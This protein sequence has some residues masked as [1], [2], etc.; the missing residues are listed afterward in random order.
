M[1]R[2][3]AESSKRPYML[4]LIWINWMSI[5]M[6]QEVTGRP[7]VVMEELVDHEGFVLDRLI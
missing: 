2:S 1:G 3:G 6:A 7:G 4:L 5:I